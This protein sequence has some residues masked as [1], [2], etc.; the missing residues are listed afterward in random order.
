MINPL[1]NLQK[2]QMKNSE[3]Q[4]CFIINFCAIYR[5]IYKNFGLFIVL[6]FNIFL[7]INFRELNY[8]L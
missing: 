8:Y 2:K 1:P 6:S 5:E 4:I 3:I 7:I